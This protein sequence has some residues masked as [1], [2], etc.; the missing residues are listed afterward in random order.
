MDD[1]GTLATPFIQVDEEARMVFLV[2]QCPG[3]GILHASDTF[4]FDENFKIISDTLKF[5]ENFK[6]VR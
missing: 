1:L 6:I 5:D 4:M 2:W 3:V